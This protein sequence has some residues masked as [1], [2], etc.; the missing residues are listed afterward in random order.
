MDMMMEGLM[1]MMMFMKTTLEEA[2]H[3]EAIL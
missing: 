2:G 3:P 1:E